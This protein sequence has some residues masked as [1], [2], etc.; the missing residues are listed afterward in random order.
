MTDTQ[1]SIDELIIDHMNKLRE[2]ATQ[3]VE[4]IE[5]QPDLNDYTTHV[6]VLESN[7]QRHAEQMLA[8]RER[9]VRQIAEKCGRDGREIYGKELGNI[10]LR[11]RFAKWAE[12]FT[13]ASRYC[14]TCDDERGKGRFFLCAKGTPGRINGYTGVVP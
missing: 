10:R 5:Q 6:S 3:D 8:L 9:V 1:P 13:Q 11:K 14:V 7:L 4:W 2:L 12:Y